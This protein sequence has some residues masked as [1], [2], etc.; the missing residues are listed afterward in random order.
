MRRLL[1]GVAVATLCAGTS[2]TTV[3][4]AA[5]PD[6]QTS[7]QLQPGTDTVDIELSD[8]NGTKVHAKFTKK[9]LNDLKLQPGSALT[10]ISPT[11]QVP[12]K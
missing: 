10:I 4:F 9:E 11:D 3:S 5:E 12:Q 8:I 6:T 1:M 7:E 2:F